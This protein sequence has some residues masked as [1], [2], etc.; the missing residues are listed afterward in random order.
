M[1]ELHTPGLFVVHIFQTVLQ[2]GTI[3]VFLVALFEIT[4]SIYMGR[5]MNTR[6]LYVSNYVSFSDQQADSLGWA[7]RVARD[8]FR[9]LEGQRQLDVASFPIK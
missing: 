9:T 8:E 4:M 7:H 3:S 6:L 5:P 1:T 2:W